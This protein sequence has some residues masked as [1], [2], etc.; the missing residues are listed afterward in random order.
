MFSGKKKRGVNGLHDYVLFLLVGGGIFDIDIPSEKKRPILCDTP[1]AHIQKGLLTQYME[2]S[3]TFGNI[4][5]TFF[6]AFYL[7]CNMYFKL[8]IN[9]TI[10]QKDIRN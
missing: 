10:D 1:S 3:Q 6:F 9:S 7:Y 4:L 2:Q 8:A 5:S